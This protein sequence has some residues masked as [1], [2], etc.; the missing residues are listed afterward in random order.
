MAIVQ[1]FGVTPGTAMGQAQLTSNMVALRD[2]MRSAG[3][4]ANLTRVVSGGM[5]GAMG[6]SMEFPDWE[7][8]STIQSEGM[9]ASVQEVSSKLPP[10]GGIGQQI[11]TM[12]ELPGLETPTDS[13]PRNIVGTSRIKVQPGKQT[14]AYDMVAK[15]KEILTRLGATV[16]VMGTVH[17]MDMGYIGFTNF[18]ESP[19]A[20][21]QSFERMGEDAEWQAHWNNSARIGN[22][23]VVSQSV[24]SFVE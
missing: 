21:V 5:V 10:S 15:S 14:F 2:A 12:M 7:T 16:R 1:F 24:W 6:M 13:I 9:P 11:G 18:F 4:N 20:M 17:S 3:R 23:E 19:Q 8:W 22:M